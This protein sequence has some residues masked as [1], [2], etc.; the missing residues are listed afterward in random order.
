MP[1]QAAIS[2]RL[3]IDTRDV[4]MTSSRRPND[5]IIADAQAMTTPSTLITLER[6]LL[7]KLLHHAAFAAHIVGH[8]DDNA[9]PE[10]IRQLGDRVDAVVHELTEFLGVPDSVA[11]DGAPM[12][13]SIAGG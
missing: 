8:L 13:T 11:R 2:L 1:R 7:E 3:W 9:Q 12:L 4:I 10:L 5:V 6:A